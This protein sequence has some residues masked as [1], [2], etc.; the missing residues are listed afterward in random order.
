MALE[1]E[2]TYR[3]Q[4]FITDKIS[5]SAQFDRA[6]KLFSEGYSVCVH[7]HAQGRSCVPPTK[8]NGV[9]GCVRLADGGSD[10]TGGSLGATLVDISQSDTDQADGEDS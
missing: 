1:P 3:N 8:P 6:Y 9:D 10:L 2:P 4:L 5:A 7:R